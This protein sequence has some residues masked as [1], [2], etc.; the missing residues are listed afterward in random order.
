[1]QSPL[2]ILRY[3]LRFVAARG[4]ELVAEE[5]VVRVAELGAEHI[6]L[7][8]GE[9]MLFPDLIPLTEEFRRL[10]RHVTIENGGHAVLGG[11]LRFDVH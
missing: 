7:T 11:C 4:P 6:V 3:A 5:I 9:P 1:M 8:G 2:P 10:K